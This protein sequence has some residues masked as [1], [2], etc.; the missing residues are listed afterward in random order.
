MGNQRAHIYQLIA[1]IYFEHA[2]GWNRDYKRYWSNFPSMINFRCI[3]SLNTYIAIKLEKTTLYR[4][5]YALHNWARVIEL[6]IQSVFFVLVMAASLLFEELGERFPNSSKTSEDLDKWKK[7]YDLVCCFLEEID[8][9]FGLIL[10][11]QIGY[12][13]IEMINDSYFFMVAFKLGDFYSGGADGFRGYIVVNYIHVLTRLFII[14]VASWHMQNQ[15]DAH[16]ILQ[17]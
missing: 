10:L 5:V 3:N 6:A 9:I 7:N 17:F 12:I 4:V 8:S 1:P 16:I 14:T 11:I 13:T 2:S 15:V